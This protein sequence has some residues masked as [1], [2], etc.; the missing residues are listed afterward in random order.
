VHDLK[1]SRVLIFGGDFWGEGASDGWN[2]ACLA[3]DAG[4]A[5]AAGFWSAGSQAALPR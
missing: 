2:S 4:L 3:I 1:N 5:A